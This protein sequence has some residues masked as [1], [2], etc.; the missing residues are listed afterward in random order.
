M[1]ISS[2]TGQLGITIRQ[3]KPE[4]TV[5]SNGR[6]GHRRIKPLSCRPR[7]RT[8]IIHLVDA[9]DCVKQKQTCQ[10]MH[11]ISLRGQI[12]LHAQAQYHHDSIKNTSDLQNAPYLCCQADLW[13]FLLLHPAAAGALTR[14]A[15][16]CR[17]YILALA[18]HRA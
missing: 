1:R 12:S 2:C 5:R 10:G 13:T 3:R 17:K 9:T 18:T 11:T 4:N 7:A 16:I 14:T 15:H 8:W 6:F